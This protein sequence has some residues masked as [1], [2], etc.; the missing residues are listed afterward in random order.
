MSLQVADMSSEGILRLDLDL[1]SALMPNGTHHV[2]DREANR[3]PTPATYLSDG[4]EKSSEQAP[5]ED[6]K[7]ET[8]SSPQKKVIKPPMPPIKEA[9]PSLRPEEEAGKEEESEK[10]VCKHFQ[11]SIRPC[12]VI[13][14]FLSWD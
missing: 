4:A 5:D 12:T 14:C 13:W 11:T 1:E 10:K 8:E 9:K 6:T 2:S 3:T 7:T